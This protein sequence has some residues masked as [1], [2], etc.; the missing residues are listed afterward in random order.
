MLDLLYVSIGNL[1]ATSYIHTYIH[2]NISAYQSTVGSRITK[3]PLLRKLAELKHHSLNSLN[4]NH[5]GMQLSHCLSGLYTV[6]M[7]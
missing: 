2:I 3:T 4:S 1:F 6:S 5:T 7:I